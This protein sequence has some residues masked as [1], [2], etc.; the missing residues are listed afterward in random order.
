[1]VFLALLAVVLRGRMGPV[2]A[3]GRQ[4]WCRVR[5]VFAWRPFR[6]RAVVLEE[7]EEPGV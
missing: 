2:R 4:V 6:R 7:V 3:K 5:K 1:V